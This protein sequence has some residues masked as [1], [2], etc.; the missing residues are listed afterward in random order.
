MI[1]S[2]QLMAFTVNAIIAN[3]GGESAHVW[4]WML[5]VASIPAVMLWFGMLVMPESPRWL[6]SKDRF[7]DALDV[8][9]QVR[10]A[11]RAH[12]ELAEVPALA[13][14][15]KKSQTGGWSTSQCRGS[16]RWS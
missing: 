14:E 2:G 13:I 15:D 10:S 16:A 5:V 12:A 1:V 4:R 7:G 11:D 8:L 3:V 9:K 6:A